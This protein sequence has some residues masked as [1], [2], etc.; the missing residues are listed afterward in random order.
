MLRKN[1]S[2]N[3]TVV[4]NANKL[5]DYHIDLAKRN[6]I[7]ANVRKEDLQAAISVYEKKRRHSV[8]RQRI[9]NTELAY[10]AGQ[11]SDQSDAAA[12]QC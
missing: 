10:G 5:W 4:H 12:T 2:V 11:S 1:N 6:V 8:P 3:K 7:L 9:S